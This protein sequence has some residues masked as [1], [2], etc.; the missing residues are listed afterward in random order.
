[1]PST[2]SGAQYS[3][4][5]RAPRDRSSHERKVRT[6]R[7]VLDA[8]VIDSTA[9][10]AASRDW[11]IALHAS[12]ALP[13]GAACRLAARALR[14]RDEPAA[15]ELPEAVH[16][17]A[18]ALRAEAREIARRE[19]DL[20]TTANASIVT[21]SDPEYPKAFR[22]LDLPPPA[23]Y[24]QGSV[25]DAPAV[26]VVGSRRATRYG[27]EIAEWFGR[28]LAEAGVTVVSG[29]AV[30]VDDAAHR[31]ALATPA[32]RTVAV[33]GC[34]LDVDYPRGHRALGR[35][36]AA[37]GARL[38]EFP[39]ARAPAPWQFPVRNRL[40]AALAD[41]C[42]VVEAAPRS[43]SLVTARLAL[44]LG[45]EVLAVPGRVGDETAFGTNALIADG[46]RPALEPRDVLEAIG[47]DVGPAASAARATVEPSGL[48]GDERVLWRAARDGPGAADALAARAELAVD[49]A[50]VALLALELAGHLRR[51]ADGVYAPIGGAF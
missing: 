23:I 45:R 26:A 43:G 31:G 17:A 12:S 18:C 15:H 5:I 1:M 6:S 42:V 46:A 8:R 30:G 51:G 9:N 11:W 39:F 38:T 33:L 27:I 29:F 2:S 47:L 13:R 50:L 37:A 21:V 14:P 41:A 10:E 24:V 35:R 25:P 3:E 40:I 44:D 36:I 19:R 49:R 32:G 4:A 48:S 34:G 7:R 20:A 16:A 22:M 28:E